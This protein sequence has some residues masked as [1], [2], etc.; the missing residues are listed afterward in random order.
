MHRSSECFDYFYTSGGIAKR[1][2][3]K[4]DNGLMIDLSGSHPLT[5]AILLQMGQIAAAVDRTKR[6][7]NFCHRSSKLF[8]VKLP[9]N[10]M[11]C[12][13]KKLFKIQEAV[14]L[15]GS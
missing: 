14:D 6:S 3:F 12:K 15:D 4:F 10:K 2:V 5:T 11:A 7:H 9:E 8:Y 1:K 13:W